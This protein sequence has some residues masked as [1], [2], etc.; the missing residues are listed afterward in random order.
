MDVVY[1]DVI[2]ENVEIVYY[3]TARSDA[4]AGPS[5]ET[6]HHQYEEMDQEGDAE[7]GP[8]EETEYHLYEEVDQQGG[9]EAAGTD[10]RP[11]VYEVDL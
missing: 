9:A 10:R 4:E 1:Y 11:P 5:E 6:E 7:A 3:N 8:S 2:Q